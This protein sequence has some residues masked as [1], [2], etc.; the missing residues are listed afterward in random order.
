MVSHKK[1]VTTWSEWIYT[2]DGSLNQTSQNKSDVIDVYF[3]HSQAIS[4]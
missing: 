1:G 3:M 4:T 2:S